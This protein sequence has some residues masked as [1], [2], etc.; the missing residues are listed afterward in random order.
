[1]TKRISANGDAVIQENEAGEPELSKGLGVC[2]K[3][4]SPET[5]RLEDKDEPCEDG[6]QR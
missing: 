1:M 4:F 6:I 3:A 5:A 2:D